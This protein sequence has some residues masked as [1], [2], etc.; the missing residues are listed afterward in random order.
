MESLPDEMLE[1]IFSNLSPYREY[2]I[3]AC[4]CKRWQRLIFDMLKQ[5]PILFEQN[6]KHGKIEW[7]SV[8]DGKQPVAISP[9]TSHSVC[10]SDYARSMFAFGGKS[11]LSIQC[12]FND[13]L[14]LDLHLLSWQTI[15]PKGSIPPPKYGCSMDCYKE[16]LILFGGS[17]LPSTNT[18]HRS[19]KEFSNDLYIFNLEKSQWTHKLFLEEDCPN[20][21]HLPKTCMIAGHYDDELDI[22]LMYGGY[23]NSISPEVNREVWC[24]HLSTWSWERQTLIGDI[25]SETFSI[26]KITFNRL[27]SKSYSAA[28]IALGQCPATKLPLLWLVCRTGAAEWTVQNLSL[29]PDPPLL[30]SNINSHMPSLILGKTLVVFR[31]TCSDQFMPNAQKLSQPKVLYSKFLND[32]AKKKLKYSENAAQNSNLVQRKVSLAISSKVYMFLFDLSNVENDGIVKCVNQ[33]E[34]TSAKLL[35]C[36]TG[37]GISSDLNAVIGKGEIVLQCA[38]KS[39]KRSYMSLSLLRSLR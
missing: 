9:R 19:V 32:M 30:F 38:V 13:L 21:V 14:R 28:V 1:V 3:V 6:L 2:E 24:L 8:E 16:Y 33:L 31:S 26:E 34:P 15:I 35:P 11:L 18:L 37:L 12:G 10:Y 39:G 7:F 29:S 36:F 27:E 20:E 17:Y 25:S 23:V 5:L 4:V 22:M